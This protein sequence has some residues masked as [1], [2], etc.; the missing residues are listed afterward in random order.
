[1]TK[2]PAPESIS[3]SYLNAVEYCPR[4]FYYEFVQGDMLENEFVLE[5]ILLHQRADQPGQHTSQDGEMIYANAANWQE[6]LSS[7]NFPTSVRCYN[8]TIV[9][10]LIPSSS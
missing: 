2:R 7:A 4:R 10:R 6:G 1:M 9:A 5:G 3:L 8:V